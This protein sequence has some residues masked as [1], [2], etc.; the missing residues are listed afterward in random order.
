MNSNI[1]FS[2]LGFNDA[3]LDNRIDRRNVEDFEWLVDSGKKSPR[4]LT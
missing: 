3:G 1:Y 4:Y 2:G